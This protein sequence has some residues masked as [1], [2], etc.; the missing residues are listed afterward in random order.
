MPTKWEKI[1]QTKAPLSRVIEYYMNPE[2]IARIHPQLVKEVKILSREGDTVT[3]EQ[4]LPFMG[5]NLLSV[6]KSSLTRATNTIETQGIGGVG[7]G[8]RM[9]RMM[10]EIPTGTEVCYTYEPKLGVLGLFVKSR[11]KRIFEETEGGD[12]KALDSLAPVEP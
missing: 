6:V 3:W 10:R 1:G 7:R 12:L 9:T 11:A 5:M 2:N 8:T 4:R